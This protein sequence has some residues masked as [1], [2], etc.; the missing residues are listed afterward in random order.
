[1]ALSNAQQDAIKSMLADV[2]SKA[3][4]AELFLVDEI[5]EPE[6][7]VSRRVD[8]T[9]FGGGTDV[10]LW[11]YPIVDVLKELATTAAKGF[12]KKWGEG[13]AHFLLPSEKS[14]RETAS[15]SHQSTLL[16]NPTVLDSLRSAVVARLKRDG[17]AARDCELAGDSV[18]AVLIAKPALLSKMVM[19]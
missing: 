15:R 13:L 11:A 14:T 9:S 10:V 2:L 3:R 17:I 16:L 8:P 4:P 19:K 12:A 18:V 6:V 5:F 7:T 1:M